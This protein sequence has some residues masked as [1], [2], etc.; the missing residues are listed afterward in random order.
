MSSASRSV[1]I[2]AWLAQALAALILLQTLF[3]KLLGAEESRYIFSTLG[4]E[5]WGRIGSAFV[6]LIAAI[7]LLTPRRATYGA[8]LAAAV[9]V[10]AIGSHLGKLGIEVQGD[11][12]LLF[13]LAWVV[14]AC[15]LLVLWLRR[16]EIPVLGPRF[17][18]EPD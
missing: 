2:T 16:R 3:F 14:F 4:V 9:M 13:A 18:P 5:P 7:L 17:G 6:E 11:R 1:Q 12:G 10:G 8:L 15:S